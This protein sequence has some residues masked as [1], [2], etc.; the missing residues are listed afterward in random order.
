M[1]LF[2]VLITCLSF[3]AKKGYSDL[4]ADQ[5]WDI[6]SY[7]GS[8]LMQSPRKR[9]IHANNIEIIKHTNKTLV[10]I[11]V[12]DKIRGY[13][14]WIQ[15]WFILAAKEK[16]STTCVLS[17]NRQDVRLFADPTIILKFDNF[18]CSIETL[19]IGLTLSR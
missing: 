11:V 14:N 13:L 12:Y 17:E 9:N 3:M 2:C 5:P 1:T 7:S 18:L 16:C 6:T 15:D 19:C 4:P 10:T 8:D